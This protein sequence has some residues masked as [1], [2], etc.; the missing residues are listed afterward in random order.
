MRRHI[1]T[2]RE[3]QILENYINNGSKTKGYRVLKHR[4]NKN[5]DSLKEEIYLAESILTKDK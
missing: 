4:V 1:F 3:K 2:N 5:L